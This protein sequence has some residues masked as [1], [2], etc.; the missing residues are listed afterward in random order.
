MMFFMTG[1]NDIW[2][3]LEVPCDPAG[4]DG[5]LDREREVQAVLRGLSRLF[6][7][8]E[9]LGQAGQGKARHGGSCHACESTELFDDEIAGG[10]AYAATFGNSMAPRGA[11]ECET[12]FLRPPALH[13]HWPKRTSKVPELAGQSF[14]A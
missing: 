11:R 1:M 10:R 14:E 7:E 9:G 13:D 6:L 3:A 12:M 2:H 5:A 4:L 8:V